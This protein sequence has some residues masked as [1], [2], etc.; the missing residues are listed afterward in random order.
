MADA[1]PSPGEE[2]QERVGERVIMLEHVG[3]TS[4]RGLAAKPIIDMLLAVPDS[5]DEQAYI[6]VMEA[7]SYVLHIREPQWHEHRLFKGSDLDVN[8]H[9]G[10]LPAVDELLK[11]RPKNIHPRTR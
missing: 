5:A 2:D 3:S 1:V 7:A 9:A 11:H 6:P 4:V 8:L 10:W